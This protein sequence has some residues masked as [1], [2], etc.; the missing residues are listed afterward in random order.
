MVAIPPAHLGSN[1]S[2]LTDFYG[3]SG[4]SMFKDIMYLWKAT[5]LWKIATTGNVD[6]QI[7][8]FEAIRSCFH[9]CYFSP[10]TLFDE[11]SDKLL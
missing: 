9:D 2:F 10:E 6:T 1:I 3:H 8:N 5:V 11:T 4:V 7:D